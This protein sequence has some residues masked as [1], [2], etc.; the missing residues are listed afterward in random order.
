MYDIRSGG[1]KVRKFCFLV[2]FV[3]L[4]QVINLN[5]ADDNTAGTIARI[6]LIRPKRGLEKDFEAGYKRHLEWRRGK[7]DSWRWHGFMF[8]QGAR[9]GSF[10]FG[11][12]QH[13]WT[14]FDQALAANEDA[15]DF[16]LNVVPY[17]DA[18]TISQITR[19][20]DLSSPEEVPGQAYL[21]E[22]VTYELRPGAER[23][24]E[25][26]IGSAVSGWKQRHPNIPFAWYKT[27]NGGV[28]PYYIFM[29][30]LN[31]WSDLRE[32][33]PFFV[34]ERND[35][36]FKDVIKEIQSDVLRFRSDLSLFQ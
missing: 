36:S 17:A 12:F 28:Q 7:N 23:T 34:T 13:D 8:A 2:V 16:T 5:A 31:R 22:M 25:S 4:S 9:A 30:T 19:L 18:F 3:M 33:E 14:D 20:R 6:I 1:I 35:V 24:F 10:L 26:M 21:I 29:R 27:I 32:S 15:S 11:T